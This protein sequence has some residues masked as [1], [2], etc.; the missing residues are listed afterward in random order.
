MTKV[1]KIAMTLVMG[2]AIF[3]IACQKKEAVRT[4]ISIDEKEMLEAIQQKPKLK[5]I[6]PINCPGYDPIRLEDFWIKNESV[7]AM[8]AK[9]YVDSSLIQKYSQ[10]FIDSIFI[11]PNIIPDS[12]LVYQVDIPDSVFRDAGYV[13]GTKCGDKVFFK[14]YYIDGEIGIEKYFFISDLIKD[15]RGTEYWR[16]R[17][18]EGA[19]ETLEKAVEECACL[20]YSESEVTKKLI[21]EKILKNI[22]SAKDA[23]TSEEIKR[24]LIEYTN[25]YN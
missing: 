11:N 19:F 20:D 24:V 18:N 23:K 17:I 10:E 3:I 15:P 16:R 25:L 4:E 14:E 12:I 7:M 22:P 5:S 21:V 8:Y 9:T 13:R 6:S 2:L 1:F